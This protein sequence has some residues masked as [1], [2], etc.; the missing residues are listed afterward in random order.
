VLQLPVYWLL[1]VLFV[2]RLHDRGKS[3]WW[4]LLL[5]LP[6]L[7]PMWLLVELLFLPG[8]PGENRFGGDPLLTRGDYLVVR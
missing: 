8:T 2:K 1:F 5:A 3:A 6:L 7:G 4:L